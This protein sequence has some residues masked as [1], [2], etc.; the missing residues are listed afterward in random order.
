MGAAT[1][2]PQV[3]LGIDVD[4]LARSHTALLHK[5]TQ[6]DQIFLLLIKI[7][8]YTHISSIYWDIFLA[9]ICYSGLQLTALI[10]S[11]YQERHVMWIV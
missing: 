3:T 5:T 9:I 11:S 6:E 1:F 10:K 8:A 2:Q 4:P 7:L